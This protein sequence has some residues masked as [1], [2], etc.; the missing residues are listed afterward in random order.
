MNKNCYLIIPYSILKNEKLKTTEKIILA[1]IISLSKKDGKCFATNAF[2][3]KRMGVTERTISKSISVLEQL[4]Y[5][6]SE[7]E[8]S[9]KRKIYINYEKLDNE[10]TMFTEHYDS[11]NEKSSKGLEKN[12]KR[13]EKTSNPLEKSSTYNNKYNNNKKNIY[14]NKNTNYPNNEASYD[15]EELMVIR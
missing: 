4:G 15:I 12:S 2:I 11:I 10:G 14:N 7:I 1:E 9:Y 8:N 13:K 6:I 3:S 5:I